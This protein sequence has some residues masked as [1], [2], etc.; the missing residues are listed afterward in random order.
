[1]AAN[2]S[3]KAFNK[4]NPENWAVGNAATPPHIT[5][6]QASPKGFGRKYLPGTDKRS[7]KSVSFSEAVENFRLTVR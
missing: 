5:T 6:F 3:G 7:F 1:M 4:F 2:K